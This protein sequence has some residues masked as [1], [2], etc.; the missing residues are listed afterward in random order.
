LSQRKL[1]FEKGSSDTKGITNFSNKWW[2]KMTHE[3]VH[4]AKTLLEESRDHIFSDAKHFSK[5][6]ISH[7]SIISSDTQAE[8]PS[9]PLGRCMMLVNIA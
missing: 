9:E 3:Y 8:E 4:S 5:D 6:M 7:W 1:V 2:G